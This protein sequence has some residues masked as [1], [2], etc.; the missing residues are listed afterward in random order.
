M[1]P[2]PTR[3][4]TPIPQGKRNIAT[5][6]NNSSL[7]RGSGFKMKIEGV[8]NA[9]QQKRSKAGGMANINIVVGTDGLAGGE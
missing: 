5:I 7:I 9:L 1:R 8:R 2:A 6:K 4:E 3:I